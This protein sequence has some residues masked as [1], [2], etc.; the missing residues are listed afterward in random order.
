MAVDTLSQK[1]NKSLRAVFEELRDIKEK[2]NK[3]I[4]S[5]PE[6]GLK[7]YKNAPDIKKAFLK[8]SKTY[9]PY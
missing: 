2:L 9:I 5:I 8:A 3:L 6:E 1:T 7:D 4:L